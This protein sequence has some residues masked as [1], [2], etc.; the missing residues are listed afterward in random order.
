MAVASRYEQ[1]CCFGQ[2][3]LQYSIGEVELRPREQGV[4]DGYERNHGSV[5]FVWVKAR[6][7][8]WRMRSG[9]TSLRSASVGASIAFRAVS[10]G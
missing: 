1:R 8:F 9:A 6:L 7:G 3:N 5:L 2:F 4:D 10:S